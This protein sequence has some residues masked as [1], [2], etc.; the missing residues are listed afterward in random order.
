MRERHEKHVQTLLDMDLLAGLLKENRIR[1][2]ALDF[3][4]PE[5]KLKL[6]EHGRPLDIQIKRGGHTESIIE[7]FMLLCNEVIA[8]NFFNLKTT[9]IYR[10][11]DR[12]DDDKI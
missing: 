8:S 5:A 4:F 6:D 2:G 10:L 1:R 3:N 7:E 9:F 12:P 11:H